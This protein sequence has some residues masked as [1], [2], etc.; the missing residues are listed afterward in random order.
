MECEYDGV[1][2]VQNRG[3][4]KADVKTVMKHLVP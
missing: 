3:R 2:L 4:R 1:Y